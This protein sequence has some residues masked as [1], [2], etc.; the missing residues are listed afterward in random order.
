MLMLFLTVAAV[1]LIA[2]VSPGPDFFFVSQTAVSRSRKEAMMG[3]LGITCGV[4][5]WAGVALLGLH[6]IIEKMAWLHN[7]IMVG[8]GL[9]LCWMGYQMLRG[10]LKKRETAAAAPQVE[11]AQ[12]GK[13]F[14]KGLLTNLAN[15]KAIIYFGSVFS[16][17]V[18]DSIGSGARWGIFLLIV[19]ETLAWFT[20]VASL[21]ALPAMRSGYQRAAKWI[22]GVAGTLFAGFG[23]HLIISR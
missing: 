16:L 19:I 13:S 12:S 11:L 5:V 10:A 23:I 3:V 22:D 4:M 2:L 1:H 9:Y 17:F 20:V 8:G 21:F 15:P 18:G 14:L 6:L 7:I